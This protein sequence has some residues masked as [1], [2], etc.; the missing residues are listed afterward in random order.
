MRA[1][2]YRLGRRWIAY[3]CS[4]D[5]SDMLSGRAMKG[6]DKDLRWFCITT[7]WP[8]DYVEEAAY[9]QQQ[10]S[11]QHASPYRCTA[12]GRRRKGPR[13]VLAEGETRL[14]STPFPIWPPQTMPAC[15]RLPEPAGIAPLWQAFRRKGARVRACGELETCRRISPTCIWWDELWWWACACDPKTA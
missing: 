10:Q 14:L 12:H 2:A 8:T 15:G 13:F 1:F 4:T 3:G 9:H 7:G 5:A 6:S 11:E